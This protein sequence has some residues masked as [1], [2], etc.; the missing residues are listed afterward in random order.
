[1]VRVLMLVAAPAAPACR[2]LRE[3][4]ALAHDGHDVHVLDATGRRPRLSLV[5]GQRGPLGGWSRQAYT[6]ASRRRF[7]VVHVHGF[8]ALPLG[9]RLARERG[10]PFVYDVDEPSFG[11]PL[12]GRPTPLRDARERALEARLGADAAVVVAGGEGVAE[13]L[14]ARYGWSGVRVVRNTLVPLPQRPLAPR[15]L[16]HAGRLED[17][18]ELE[19]VAAAAE[20]LPLPVEAVGPADATRQDVAERL[21][22]A[23]VALVPRSGR[24]AGHRLALP[25]TLFQA[26]AAGVPVVATDVGELATV[27]RGYRLGTLYAPGD[28]ASLEIAVRALLERY[29]D[30]VRAVRRAVPWLSWASDAAVLRDVYAGLG[31]PRPVLQLQG[32]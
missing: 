26:V 18:R 15:G 14:E 11:R 30:H 16:L 22:D 17:D 9:E 29:E 31:A 8:D 13:A 32:S 10:V 21:Q 5:P 6:E 7:D 25:D 24:W 27:V 28:A 3:A 4:S 23:G 1:M 2:A 12:A 19:V 20:R